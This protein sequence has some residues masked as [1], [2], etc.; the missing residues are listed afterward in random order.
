M[1]YRGTRIGI[2]PKCI[3]SVIWPARKRKHDEIFAS[4]L[5]KVIFAE[6]I[7]RAKKNEIPRAT[8][9]SVD[10]RSRRFLRVPKRVE[11]H[12]VESA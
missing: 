7:D 9:R 1:E 6:S 10:Q 4:R 3:S 2:I 12:T 8:L 5:G 11:F